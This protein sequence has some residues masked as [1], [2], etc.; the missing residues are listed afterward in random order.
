MPVEIQFS[1]V[2]DRPV[3]KVFHFFAD[4]HVRNHPR[5]DADME[6]EQIS[7]GPIGVGT[8]IRRRNRRGGKPVDGTM[9]VV[10]FERD[11]AMGMVIHDGPVE[12]RGRVLFEAVGDNQTRLTQIIELPGMDGSM[13]KTALMSALERAGR[14][15]KELIESEV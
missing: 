12:M 9:E 10:E 8:M 1:Q 13:D 2:I 7:E 5:W 6:L 11:R 14:T 15:R 4:E 3:A